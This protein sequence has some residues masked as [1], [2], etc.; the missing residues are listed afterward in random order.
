MVN[1]SVNKSLYSSKIGVSLNVMGRDDSYFE[2]NVNA[3]S[4]VN[5]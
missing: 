4:I 1:E 3:S 5:S 2:G